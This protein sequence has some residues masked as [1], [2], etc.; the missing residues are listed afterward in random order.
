MLIFLTNLREE[1]GEVVEWMLPLIRGKHLMMTVTLR[2][3]GAQGPAS[4]G[5]LDD[6]LLYGAV[7]LYKEQR[8]KL[9]RFWEKQGLITLD[10]RPSEVSGTLVHKYLVLKGAGV[11]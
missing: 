6:A 10:A 1:D 11:L 8:L 3:E 9:R 7:E 4:I 5:E 2:E